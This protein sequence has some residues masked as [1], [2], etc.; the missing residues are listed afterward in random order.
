MN[1]PSNKRTSPMGTPIYGG[2]YAAPEAAKLARA[3]ANAREERE[4]AQAHARAATQAQLDADR[5]RYAA[6][7]EG[8][9]EAADRKRR[10]DLAQK[11]ADAAQ[12]AMD[13]Y[14][15]E[16]WIDGPGG[17]VLAVAHDPRGARDSIRAKAGMLAA[18]LGKVQEPGE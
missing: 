6:T 12:A 1:A 18:M 17:P 10:D 8:R 11:Y 5:A 4:A 3:A 14:T 13:H 15:H 9:A 2:A 7:P 16:R